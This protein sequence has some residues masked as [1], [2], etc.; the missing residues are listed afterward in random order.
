MKP[1]RI[2]DRNHHID[3]QVHLRLVVG[4]SMSLI[5]MQRELT[6]AD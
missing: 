5:K 1:R 4:I 2:R 6:A 3:S